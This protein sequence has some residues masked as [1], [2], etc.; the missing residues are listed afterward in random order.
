MKLDIQY[1]LEIENMTSFT[2][3]LDVLQ[4]KKND[5]TYVISYNYPNIK[6]DS[7]YN[8]L[9]LDFSCYNTY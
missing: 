8:S 6:L 3:E 7:S 1:Y 2:T 9:P 5:I 4:D